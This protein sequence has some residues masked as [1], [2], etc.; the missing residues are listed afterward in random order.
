MYSQALTVLSSQVM[1][2][3]DVE[4]MILNS[5]IEFENKIR[6]W[7]YYSALAP[8]RVPLNDILPTSFDAST[9]LYFSLL[10]SSVAQFSTCAF[11]TA[12]SIS[13]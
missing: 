13:N 2:D 8:K 11:E 1:L 5:W 4:R 12:T 3:T 9:L 10:Y 6:K 7:N